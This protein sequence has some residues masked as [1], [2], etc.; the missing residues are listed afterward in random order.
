MS[1]V[2][3]ILASLFDLCSISKIIKLSKS[4]AVHNLVILVKNLVLRTVSTPIR[5]GLYGSRAK[6]GSPGKWSD[7]DVVVAGDEPLWG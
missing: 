2:K 3:P 5:V 6:G 1:F 7:I 4:R